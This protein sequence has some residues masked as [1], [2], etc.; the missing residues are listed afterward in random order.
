MAAPPRSRSSTRDLRR[1]L[2]WSLLLV[3]AVGLVYANSLRAPFLF[4]DAGAVVTNPTIRELG[5][6]AIFQPPADGSTTTGRPLVNFSFAVSHALGGGTPSGHR[7]VNVGL[8]AVAALLVFAILR[9]LRLFEPSEGGTAGNANLAAFAAALL[10]AVHPLQTESVVCIAQRTEVLCGVFY[11]ATIAAFLRAVDGA[12]PSGRRFDWRWGTVSLLASAAGMASKEVMVT[13]PVAVILIDRTFVAGS[14]RAAWNARRGYYLALA[15]TW[16]PLAVLVVGTG[17]ARGVAAGF[18]LGV[19]PWAY[20]LTQAEALVRY[21]GLVLWPHPLVLDYGTAV[22]TS[23]SDV[24]VEVAI[25]LLLLAA[26]GWALVRRPRLGLVGAW[27]FLLLAPSSSFVPLVAQTVAEHRMYLPLAGLIGFFVHGVFAWSGSGAKAAVGFLLL[28]SAL[29]TVARNADYR[30]E[31]RIWSTSVDAYPSSARAHGNLALVLR[32]RGRLP[33]A[34]KHFARAVALDPAYATGHYN[35]GVMLLAE[36]REAEAI[37]EFEAALR[38][39]P[40]HL[41]AMVNLGTALVRTGRSADAIA[42]FE[43][44]RALS[45][46]ADVLFNLGVAYVEAGQSAEAVRQFTEAL[47]LAPG[48]AEAHV[49]I[50]RIDER[51]RRPEAAE[52]RYRAALALVPT[53]AVAQARLGLLLARSER[54]DEA[55]V[56]LREAVRL[57][58]ADVDARANLGNVYLVQGRAREAGAQ[59]EEALRLRPGDTRLRE[60]LEAARAQLR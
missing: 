6:L 35:W 27:F 56:A 3:A 15:G 7:A 47:R 60:S 13:A 44:A 43:R 14:F 58:P 53:H 29:V 33:E 10:W 22:V 42:L 40:R 11:L 9:R 41:D 51:E 28:G 45:P 1:T 31:L 37:R 52:Q 12:T 32:D 20:L 4:D 55:L 19:S 39:A 30:D 25:V 49:Q 23:V 18:S 36:R 2:G 34:G 26:T 16:I 21:L 57:N 59:Y 38:S 5:S 50:G 54:W 24:F 17:G 46:T 8:H 48:L